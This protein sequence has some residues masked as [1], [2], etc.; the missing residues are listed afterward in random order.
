M[1]V[2]GACPVG[3]RVPVREGVMHL[4]A[5]AERGSR[6]SVLWAPQHL[7]SCADTDGDV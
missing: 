7:L 5:P 6:Q 4:S 2:T 3:L 1:Q